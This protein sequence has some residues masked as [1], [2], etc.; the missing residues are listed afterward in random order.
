MPWTSPHEACRLPAAGT[1]LARRHGVRCGVLAEGR[2]SGGRRVCLRRRPVSAPAGLSRA[3]AGRSR[4]ALLAWRRLDLGLQGMDV[5]H[6]AGIHGRRSDVRLRRLPA[7]AAARVSDRARGLRLSRGLGR[8]RDCTA[9]RRPEPT[10]HRRPFGG[11]SLRRSA[12]G[13]RLRP[14][15][16]RP[17]AIDHPWLPTV[18]GSVRLRPFVGTV[19]AAEVPRL[20]PA[21][22]RRRER[23][24]ADR[25]AGTAVPRRLRIERLSPSRAAGARLRRR[26]APG[27]GR[28]QWHR[29]GGT[30]A[31]HVELRGG[32]ADGPWVPAALDFMARHARGQ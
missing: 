10:L 13:Q 14:G 18:V 30:D 31:F 4:A 23:D 6:G 19:D 22:R 26:V 29:D 16:R 7:R 15:G 27:R 5:V 24:R 21:Q 17:A 32:E 8:A 11:G 28:C 25:D 1:S 9:R 2:G 3:E 12:V 20:R